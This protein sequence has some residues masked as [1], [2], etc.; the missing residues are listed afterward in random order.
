MHCDRH[1]RVLYRFQNRVFALIFACVDSDPI[2][3][4]LSFDVDLLPAYF[5]IFHLYLGEY[6]LREFICSYSGVGQQ[7]H[8]Q[9]HFQWQHF[10]RCFGRKGSQIRDLTIRFADPGLRCSLR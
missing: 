4:G 5:L 8:Q 7:R 2:E 10:S 3:V 6:R 9:Y 1:Y